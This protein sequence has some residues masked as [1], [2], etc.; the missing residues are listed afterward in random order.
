MS[1][2]MCSL[3]WRSCPSRV[4]VTEGSF[5]TWLLQ[6]FLLNRTWLEF[7]ELNLH[8]LLPTTDQACSCRHFYHPLSVPGL[9]FTDLNLNVSNTM[10]HTP[11]KT[12]HRALVRCT[13]NGLRG[14]DAHG[15]GPFRLCLWAGEA[16]ASLV[17]VL[18]MPSRF[19]ISF[20]QGKKDEVCP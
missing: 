18:Q 19:F 9:T 12:E 15:A 3:N 13:P 10:W 17:R 1:Q 16:D 5:G 8:A 6:V 2:I 14:E 20:A 4:I 11:S 7:A